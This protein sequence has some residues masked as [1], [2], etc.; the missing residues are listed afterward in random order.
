M[1]KFLFISILLVSA[2]LSPIAPAANAV[3]ANASPVSSQIVIPVTDDPAIGSGSNA[4]AAVQ[5]TSNIPSLDNFSKAVNMG[6][7]GT[8]A[9]VYVNNLFA[10]KV[11]QQPAGNVTYVSSL[12]DT[13]TNFSQA[14]QYGTIGLLAHNYLAGALFSKLAVGME[15]DVVNGDGA[16]RRFVVSEI[17]RFQAISP[18]DPYSSFIDLDKGAQLSST[19]LFSKVYMG[20][21][22]V[23]MQTCINA[24]GV[25]SW[26]RLFVT[27]TPI[28]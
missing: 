16:V 26:G 1:N 20:G 14:A 23:V 11:V 15:V 21:N 8:V 2:M 28:P 13:A 17:A 9:G 27:A 19:D 7:S 10:Y 12:R 3:G 4:G 24:D 25:S 5:P 22:K 18:N 6:R